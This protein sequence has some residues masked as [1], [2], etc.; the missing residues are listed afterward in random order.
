M[1]ETGGA[2]SEYRAEPQHDTAGLE[3]ETTQQPKRLRV[4]AIIASPPTKKCRATLKTLE[5]MTRLFPDQVQVD[6]YQLGRAWPRTPTMP[7]L[8]EFKS[9]R[10]PSVYV[11]GRPICKAEPPDPQQLEA[12][13]SEELARGPASWEN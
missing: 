8:L 12:A 7:C 9:W 10:A 2:E 5:E 1:I 4:E 13:I 6:I 3:E 11:N